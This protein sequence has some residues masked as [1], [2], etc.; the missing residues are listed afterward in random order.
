MDAANVSASMLMRFPA[1][2]AIPVTRRYPDMSG[3]GV[4]VVASVSSTNTSIKVLPGTSGV[5]HSS[6]ACS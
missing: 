5:D 3:Q 2:P 6:V 1:G 4:A